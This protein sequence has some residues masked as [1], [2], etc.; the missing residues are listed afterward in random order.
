MTYFFTADEHSDHKNVIAHCDRPFASLQEMVAAQ[1]SRHNAKVGPKDVV[2]HLGDVA[3]YNPIP[4]I[5]QLNGIHWLVRGNHDRRN[6]EACYARVE[7]VLLLKGMKL[8]L[9]HYAHLIWPQKHYG[10]KHLFGHSHGML[11]RNEPGSMDIGQ[12][13]HDFTPLAFD[14]VRRLLW[15]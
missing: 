4:Y 13:C 7:D 2:I 12:D 10:F 14:E 15:K 3:M 5:E 6:K 1:V 9:S 11:K 8:F